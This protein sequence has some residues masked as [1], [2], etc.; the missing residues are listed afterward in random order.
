MR[1]YIEPVV[2]EKMFV[3]DRIG[4]FLMSE[5]SQQNN[6]LSA[7]ILASAIKRLI[8]KKIK[9]LIMSLRHKIMLTIQKL[10]P[11]SRTNSPVK[12]DIRKCVLFLTIRWYAMYKKESV[13]QRLISIDAPMLIGI[14]SDFNTHIKEEEVL[15]IVHNIIGAKDM[16]KNKT[17]EYSYVSGINR[18]LQYLLPAVD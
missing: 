4:M 11:L 8:P 13:F 14:N 9:N 18:K 16:P 5:F 3:K 2:V 17:S 12:V 1:E 6:I 15:E 7:D 10:V